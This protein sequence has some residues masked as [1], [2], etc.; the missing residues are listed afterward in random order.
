MS[1]YPVCLNINNRNCVIVGG[2][3]VAERKALSLL[4]AGGLI[5]VISPKVTN[6]LAKLAEQ[7]QVSWVKREYQG[8]DLKQAYLV[9]AATDKR[10]LNYQ[11]SQ[12]AKRKGV[13]VNVVDE[14]ELSDFITTA[15]VKRG[16]LII[17][18]STSGACPALARWIKQELEEK[19]SI[20]YGRLL[21]ILEK[22][23][24]KVKASVEEESARQQVIDK[25]INSETI[26]LAKSG[27]YEE[28]E[29][30]VLS[31]IS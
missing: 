19:Y 23:R 13:L 5:K 8:S 6:K 22:A 20:A 1:H 28:L 10:E 25:L 3:K 16:K 30:R 9:I 14:L 29:R 2:G 4:E 12:D 18:V 27:K 17:S 31:C 24:L 21:E 26:S 11:I 15:V 7:G